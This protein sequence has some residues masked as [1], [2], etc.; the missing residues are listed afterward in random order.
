MPKFHSI[1]DEKLAIEFL[2]SKLEGKKNISDLKVNQHFSI[3]KAIELLEL[4]KE[5]INRLGDDAPEWKTDDLEDL[6]SKRKCD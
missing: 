3:E 2:L 4:R 5:T 1:R 6:L